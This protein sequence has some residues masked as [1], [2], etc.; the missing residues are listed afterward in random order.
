MARYRRSAGAPAEGAGGYHDDGGDDERWTRTDLVVDASDVLAKDAQADQLHPAEE[1][2]RDDEGR[3]AVDGEPVD[4]LQENDCEGDQEGRDRHGRA[5][6]RRQLQWPVGKGEE[7]VQG[8]AHELAV[9]EL[10]R[11]GEPVGSGA[12]HSL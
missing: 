1:Q 4:Q 11:A 7:A 5:E 10:G 12:R 2:H 6:R 3:P 9:G 8:E